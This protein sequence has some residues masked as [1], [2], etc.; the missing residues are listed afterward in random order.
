MTEQ[1]EEKKKYL[2][3]K[4]DVF[5][6]LTAV[7]YLGNAKWLCQCECG[8]TK[9]VDSFSLRK[10]N[11]KCCGCTKPTRHGLSGSPEHRAW[12]AMK[13]RCNNPNCKDYPNYGGRGI[14]VCERW[15]KSFIDYLQDI[16]SKP[17]PLHTIDRIDVNGHYCPENCR[18]ATTKEQADNKRD[19]DTG[20][21]YEY[22]GENKTLVKWSKEF[23]IDDNVVRNRLNKGWTLEKSL[24]EPVKAVRKFTKEEENEMIEKYRDGISMEELG[25][26][27]NRRSSSIL[28]ML[29]RRNVCHKKIKE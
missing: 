11:A 5:G 18:W 6:L 15:D 14:K 8:N 28:Q 7:E 26:Q 22:N 25:R 17:S 19:L 24:T 23:N 21:L 29:Q 20:E 10:R 2:D 3:I 9:I 4:D 1:I 16:G 13:T 12:K 27:Y